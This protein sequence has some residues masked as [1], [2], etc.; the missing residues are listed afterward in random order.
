MAKA[1]QWTKESIN[2]KWYSVCISH[3][4]VPMIK[5]N[6]DKTYTVIDLSLIHI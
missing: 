3:K 4:H 1:Y 2:G 5:H 6:P